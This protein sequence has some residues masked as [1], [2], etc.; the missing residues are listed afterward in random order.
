M[1][2]R[3][4]RKFLPLVE[5][6][7]ISKEALLGARDT[8]RARGVEV[9]RVLLREVGVPRE[10]M[11]CALA[12][13]FGCEPIQYD[14]RLPV[15]THLFEGL[16]SDVLLL[17]QWF[18]V[19]MQGETVVIAAVN[20]E[21]RVMRDEA[22]RLVPAGEYEFRVALA[23]DVQWLIQDYLHAKPESIIGIER[24]GLAFWRNIMA[25]WRTRLACYRTDLARVRTS[26]KLVRWGLAMAAFGD[27]LARIKIY[28]PLKPYYGVVFI[29]G[30]VLALAGLCDYLKTRRRR[31]LAP[32]ARRLAEVTNATVQF[33]DRY[34]LD[35]SAGKKTK[36]TMLARMG[37]MVTAYCSILAPEPASKERTHLARER[38][39]LAA[40]RTIAACHRT[41]Y[42]RAR[43]GLSFIR[44]GVAFTGAGL[45]MRELL[46]PGFVFLDFVLM[47]AGLFLAVEGLRWYLPAREVGFD[48]AKR[49]L[50]GEAA[51]CGVRHD[52][53]KD[54]SSVQWPG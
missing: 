6:G 26:L 19:I 4:I 52:V 42:A 40:Q 3:A 12:G 38:N 14:E 15:P 48:I 25:Q 18:P 46:G 23:E 9:E 13:H 35:D 28:H 54:G 20:P 16:K 41:I 53:E 39:M 44:T 47:A 43:T 30:L 51:G 27:A 17:H 29:A 36:G 7:V 49:V 33:T 31:M 45:L 2:D 1:T 8:A 10:A 5:D 50:E 22:M 21:S 34:H 32:G 24:T 37:N 11:L